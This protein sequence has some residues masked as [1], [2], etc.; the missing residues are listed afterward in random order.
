[1]AG[2]QTVFWLYSFNNYILCWIMAYSV[3]VSI[4]PQ[5]ERNRTGSFQE[6]ELL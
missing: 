4:G 5:I 6:M 3:Y 1:M 2:R